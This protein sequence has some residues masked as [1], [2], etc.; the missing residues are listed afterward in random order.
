MCPVCAANAAMAVVSVTTTGG[1]ASI[2][3]KILRFG[4]RRKES[5]LKEIT[6]RRKEDGYGNEQAR[7]TEGRA[8]G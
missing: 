2:G 3:V 1:L 6:Q 4:R 7:T 8:A 5:D